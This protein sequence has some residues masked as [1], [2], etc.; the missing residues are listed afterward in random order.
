MAQKTKRFDPIL[1]G[2][3]LLLLCLP[4]GWAWNLTARIMSPNHFDKADV[5]VAPI[6]A[7]PAP[8]AAVAA[9]PPPGAIKGDQVTIQKTKEGHRVEI[10]I[11]PNM[12]EKLKEVKI[13]RLTVDGVSA[14]P[15]GAIVLQKFAKRKKTDPV[16]ITFN[17]SKLKAKKGQQVMCEFSCEGRYES[18]LTT[19]LSTTFPIQVK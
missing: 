6:L 18:G 7:A 4:V 9:P 2:I 3:A 10:V 17:T 1:W 16:R 15:S 8:P 19:S 12:N 13:T 11:Q 14:L 5:A